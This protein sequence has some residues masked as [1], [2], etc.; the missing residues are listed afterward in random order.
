MTHHAHYRIGAISNITG[1]S[2]DTLRYYEKIGLLNKIKRSS[3]G[4]RYYDDDNLSRLRFIK[5][6]QL[7]NFS[8]SEIAELLIFRENPRAAKPEIRE[9]TKQ[10]IDLLRKKI[11]SIK[12]LHDELLLLFNLCTDSASEHCPIISGLEDIASPNIS[13]INS[14]NL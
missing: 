8:L 13:G 9:I 5:N 7:M 14:A 6:A 3:S 1:M 12:Q 2:R 10:K 11:E 4:L